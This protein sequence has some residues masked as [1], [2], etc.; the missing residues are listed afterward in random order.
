MTISKG[1]QA[2]LA[3]CVNNT[4][5]CL[6]SSSDRNVADFIGDVAEMAGWVRSTGVTGQYTRGSA[7]TIYTMGYSS[8]RG[9]SEVRERTYSGTTYYI[10]IIYFYDNSSGYYIIVNYRGTTKPSTTTVFTS[11]SWSDNN[12][13]DIGTPRT[14]CGYSFFVYYSGEGS[15]MSLTG[16]NGLRYYADD[17]T[18]M[19]WLANDGD[20][21]DEANGR[22]FWFTPAFDD[23]GSVSKDCFISGSNAITSVINTLNSTNYMATN[24]CS[25]LQIALYKMPAYDGN[26]FIVNTTVVISTADEVKVFYVKPASSC[27]HTDFTAGSIHTEQ[28]GDQF[29]V[30]TMAGNGTQALL[31]SE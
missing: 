29:Y 13:S 25:N 14:N 23:A 5:N 1:V 31:W 17:A 27:L 12:F 11:T 22:C 9:S 7:S 18:G 2:D 16:H 28:N 30:T 6:L 8:S 26:N 15:N 10:E 3:L 24:P 20:S 21:A 4:A 19:F